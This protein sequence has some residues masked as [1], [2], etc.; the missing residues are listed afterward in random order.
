MQ[1]PDEVSSKCSICKNSHRKEILN[2]E[3]QTFSLYMET[4]KFHRTT[5]DILY[6]LVPQ[7]LLHPMHM[8]PLGAL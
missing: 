8:V 5:R 7:E 3:T 1:I 2:D 6:T 4:F